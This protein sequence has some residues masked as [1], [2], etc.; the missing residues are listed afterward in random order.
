MDVRVGYPVGLGQKGGL[1]MLRQVFRSGSAQHVE[2]GG[3]AVGKITSVGRDVDVEQVRNGAFVFNV[4]ALSQVVSENV[5]ERVGAVVRAHGEEV[6]NVT[7]RNDALAHSA[8]LALGDEHA[9]W[10]GLGQLEAPLAQPREKLALTTDLCHAV[11]RLLDATH[12]GSA[13]RAVRRIAGV[14]WQHTTS[15]HWSSSCR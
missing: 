8:N 9:P 4:P 2:R 7:P 5:V 13:V 14:A 6:V 11:Y 15:L 1:N 12:A 3:H 10:V